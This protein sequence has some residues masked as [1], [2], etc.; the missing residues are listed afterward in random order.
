[1]NTPLLWAL[2]GV[3]VSA[4][5][6]SLL[7]LMVAR[8]IGAARILTTWMAMVCLSVLGIG[9]PALAEVAHRCWLVLH[10]GQPSRLDTT[11]AALSITGL[12]VALSRAEWRRRSSAAIREDVHRHHVE[13]ARILEG[14]DPNAGAVVWLPAS[15]PLAYSLS[16]RPPMVVAST[17]LRSHLD[18]EAVTAV[19]AHEQA[20]LTRH[21]HRLVQAAELLAN[22]FPWLP[23]LKQSP[24]LVGTL[25]ELDADAHAAHRVGAAGLR[26]ALHALA[27]FGPPSA[28]PASALSAIGAN[29]RLRLTRLNDMSEEHVRIPAALGPA[30]AAAAVMAPVLI[31]CAVMAITA[32]TSCVNV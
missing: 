17:G 10:D 30:T 2:G 3:A 19:L 12:I 20:H 22:G 23:L 18:P 1:M 31:V 21:H 14:A 5:S 25:V 8:G 26:R 15:Q 29:T 32:L 24:T 13:M 27:G 9:L 6:P 28:V 4:A 7:R 16:G 11:V